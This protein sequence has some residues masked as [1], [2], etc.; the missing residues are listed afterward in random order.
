VKAASRNVKRPSG[1]QV[2]DEPLELSNSDH[3]SVVSSILLKSAMRGR[4]AL[5][6]WCLAKECHGD[7]QEV[8]IALRVRREALWRKVITTL[9]YTGTP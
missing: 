3:L 5:K 8:R 1:I 7:S 2:P 4:Q 9:G 6:T